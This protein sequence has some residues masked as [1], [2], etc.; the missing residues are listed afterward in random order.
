MSDITN[1][2]QNLDLQ[3][4]RDVLT[5]VND[6]I[7]QKSRQGENFIS[8]IDNS[9]T[10]RNN[11]SAANV[12]DYVEYIDQFC[13][14]EGFSLEYLFPEIESLSLN[15]SKSTKKVQ[16]QFISMINEPYSWK[17]GSS[18]VKNDPVSF[19]N[20]PIT[21]S[22]MERLNSKFDLKLNSV[23]VSYYK[24]GSVNTRLHDDGEDTMDPNQPICVL[25]LGVQRRIEFFSKHIDTLNRKAD[26]SL[27]PVS[28]SL[29][30][31]K[32]GCQQNFR[33]RVRKNKNIR[34][35]RFCLSFR[36]FVPP[37]KK[38][39]FE[40]QEEVSVTPDNFSTPVTTPNQD[41]SATAVVSEQVD[42]PTTTPLRAGPAGK[43]QGTAINF[44]NE[45]GFSPFQGTHSSLNSSKPGSG[46]S[47]KICV[48]F[49]TSIT[50][51]ISGEKLS[52][53]GRIFVNRSQS[54]ALIGDIMDELDD[55]FH[56]HTKHIDNVDKIIFSLGTNEVKY[57]NCYK[58]DI[59]RRFYSPLMKLVEHAKNLFPK[60]Q[61]VFQCVLPIFTFY[62]YTAEAVHRFNDLL[63][64]VCKR[65]GS[66]FFDCFGYF[67]DDQGCN[68]RGNLYRDKFHLSSDTGIKVL[69]RHLKSVIHGNIFNPFMRNR[70]V[71]P[72]Y[73]I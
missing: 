1:T 60:A 6:L 36:S 31:M 42:S 62:T 70:F 3:Q 59:F 30:I 72:Y 21:K 34:K 16:N 14:D 44:S 37:Q 43:A 40:D 8:S 25:S 51:D 68:I 33:H 2:L 55:F 13:N 18:M 73:Y 28:G 11:D 49:G 67:L 53:K 65:T 45:Q 7:V 19:D 41:N 54:G 48:L 12:D 24:S 5:T 52:R 46:S 58:V 35:G 64:E 29:Y 66:I 47:E 61:I 23:L 38:V 9:I 20:F 56:E 71:K 27:S 32:A 69:A 26:L 39:T 4:L 57:L 17:A 10:L 50:M 63:I 15:D 22:I